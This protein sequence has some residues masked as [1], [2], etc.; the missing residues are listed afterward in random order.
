MNMHKRIRLT[1]HDRKEIWDR[2]RNGGEKVTALA[3]SYRVS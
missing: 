2:Y 1:P 3:A